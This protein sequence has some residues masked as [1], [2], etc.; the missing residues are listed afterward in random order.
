MIGKLTGRV[1]IIGDDSIILDVS[2]VGYLVYISTNTLSNI[3]DNA[4]HTLF[5]DTHVREDAITLFGFLSLEEKSSFLKLNL[6]S[7]VGTRVALSILSAM[8]SNE[9]SR[10][11]SCGD[12]DAFKRISGIGSKLADRIILELKD[13][14]T[15]LHG[16]INISS[17]DPNIISDA[18]SALINLGINKNDAASIVSKIYKENP[19]YKIDDIIRTALKTRSN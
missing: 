17:N 4:I 6:V 16:N 12:K 9:I 8:D 3:V 19:N 14:F 13:K 10:A 1:E 11:I 2:G 5:I 15:N 7:G 18:V